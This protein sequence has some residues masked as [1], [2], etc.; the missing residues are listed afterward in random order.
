[1]HVR[2]ALNLAAFLLGSAAVA[3]CAGPPREPAPMLSV[4]AG[5]LGIFDGI[6]D[7]FEVGVAYRFRPSPHWSLAPAV[8]AT[9]H[10]NGAYFVYS[11]L[12][13]DFWLGTRWLLVPSIGM[14]LFEDGKKLDLGHT[15]EF[16]S[17]LELGYRF[18]NHWR[19]GLAMFHL[20]NGGIGDRN[21]GTE[22]LV[23]SI[24]IPLSQRGSVS[25]P[26]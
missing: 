17:G 20:S 23:V 6:G 9:V 15:V 3:A 8:G 25:T 18:D 14:G 5:K 24:S 12:R 2:Q 13:R 26:D 16:R 7:P 11:E 21:P 22:A 10:D 4:S 19:V 1:M